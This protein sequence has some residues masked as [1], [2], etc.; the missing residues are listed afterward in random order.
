MFKIKPVSIFGLNILMIIASWIFYKFPQGD[1]YLILFMIPI[2]FIF[3]PFVLKFPA[4]II[5]FTMNLA[6]F[7][8]YRFIGALDTVDV[9]V[10][11]VL[12]LVVTGGS[13]LVR[14]VY[15]SFLAYHKID[16]LEKQREYNSIVNE[17]EAVDRRGRRI[18]NELSRI[19]RLYEVTKTLAPALKTEDLLNA[20]FDFLEKN[21]TFQVTHLLTFNKGNFS[22]SISKSVGNKDRYAKNSEQPEHEKIIE[23]ARG[24]ELKPFFIEK[25]EEPKLFSSMKV[26]GETFMVFPLFVGEKLYAI[27]AIEG[28]SRSSYGRFRILMP[29]IALEFR[30]V[31]LYEQVQELSIIDGL[32]EVYLRRY[33]MDRLEEEV[34]R[35]S[36]LGLTFSIGM[37]DVD[38]FKDCN[39]TYGHLVG[40]VVL[41]NISERLKHSVREVDMV[42]RY[43]GE[44]FCILL[45]ETNKELA[46]SVAER[47]RSSIEVEDIKA[48]DESIRMTVSVGI[49]TYPEDA[50]EVNALIEKSD[51]ALYKAKRKGRNVVCTL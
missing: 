10:M 34:D 48:F 3:V 18:E 7:L 29:Q 16:I 9:F 38:H 30:K 49:A 17:L 23:Y 46:V 25:K 21:F 1:E 2:V 51:T 50:K 37:I 44:E 22:K 11:T 12:L 36:R 20:L 41:K 45:P 40:D 26:K 31:E 35:A 32:T 39:D 47:L 24:R 15:D 5:L 27:F 4:A 33:L 14:F 13:Y 42:S 28:A 43:G 19:S 6:F 8:F